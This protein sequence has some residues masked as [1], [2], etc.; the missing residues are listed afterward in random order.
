MKFVMVKYFL[1]GCFLVT[2]FLFSLKTVPIAWGKIGS[3]HLKD[4]KECRSDISR[5]MMAEIPMRNF[6]LNLYGGFCRATFN[7]SCNRRIRVK[8]GMLIKDNIYSSAKYIEQRSRKMTEFDNL[9]KSRGIPFLY[10]QLPYKMDVENKMLPEG[11]HHAVYAD[12][13]KLLRN[14]KQSKVD[15]LD[16][17]KNF[18]A[19][20]SYVNRYFYKTDHHWNGDAIFDAVKLITADVCRR[21]KIVDGEA[22]VG[23]IDK[24]WIRHVKECCFVGSAGKRTGYYFSG[25]DDLVFRTRATDVKQSYFIEDFR[26]QANCRHGGFNDVFVDWNSIEGTGDPFKDNQYS[27]YIG[28]CK[29]LGC[30]RNKEAPIK[31]KLVVIGESFSSPVWV[32]LSSLFSEVDAIDPR[33]LKRIGLA[34]YALQS[35]PDVVIEMANSIIL[36]DEKFF[37]Y[38]MPSARKWLSMKDLDEKKIGSIETR[39]KKENIAVVGHLKRSH[40][41]VLTMENVKSEAEFVEVVLYD[42]LN[43]KK[44]RRMVFDVDFYNRKKN[45]EWQF[46]VPDTGNWDLRIV[47]TKSAVFE[48]IL[49]KERIPAEPIISKNILLKK[50]PQNFVRTC[51]LKQA[52]QIAVITKLECQGMASH[53]ANTVL[54]Q[55][56]FRDANGRILAGLDL[57]KNEKYGEW[58]YIPA[59]NGD[60]DFIKLLTVPKGAASVTVKISHFNYREALIGVKLFEVL[61][62]N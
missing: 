20:P 18:A 48:N 2:L 29:A 8:G 42:T 58:F 9:L 56:E 21:L 45:Y 17:R 46:S 60:C 36:D 62:V 37:E 40:G 24:S 43:K 30:Y 31:K 47:S 57:S 11:V 14:L 13:D 12:I 16:L 19:T 23:Q 1:T 22:L 50:T 53:K 10:I 55:I 15:V 26:Y 3:Y 27:S 35:K 34:E 28:Y 44:W 32:M 59:A 52:K 39:G 38:D 41:Y 61:S 25:L 5:S 33:A 6:F 49:L 4:F 7:S 54:A 51:K